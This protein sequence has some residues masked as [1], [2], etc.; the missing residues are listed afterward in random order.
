MRCGIDSSK[1]CKVPLCGCVGAVYVFDYEVV[2][3]KVHE[4]TVFF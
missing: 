3:D 4:G 2:F 1:L